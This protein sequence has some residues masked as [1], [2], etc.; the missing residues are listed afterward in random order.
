MIDAPAHTK[1]RLRA[2]RYIGVRK[3]ARDALG[4]SSVINAIYA[5]NRVVLSIIPPRLFPRCA[6]PRRI[7]FFLGLA[8]TLSRRLERA[9]I[10]VANKEFEDFLFISLQPSRCSGRSAGGVYYKS[11]V[12]K[13]AT[14]RKRRRIISYFFS[15][16]SIPHRCRGRDK[17]VPYAY[18]RRCG[19]RETTRF[20][21][22]F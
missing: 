22:G 20:T 16:L 12:F 5:M 15:D 7:L 19:T 8:I 3:I 14:T 10:A 1:R 13:S 21:S 6:R 17:Q 11:L 9:P 2:S 18:Q 4:R